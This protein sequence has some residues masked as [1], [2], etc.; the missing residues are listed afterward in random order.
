[1][2][3]LIDGNILLDVL[4]KKR[5]LITLGHFPNGT[6]YLFGLLARILRLISHEPVI[7]DCAA[8]CQRLFSMQY[9]FV[10]FHCNM[11]NVTAQ[12]Q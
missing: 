9:T 4:Q 6:R 3:F 2:K 8:C 12:G 1:M 10:S 5:C 11:V 7:T